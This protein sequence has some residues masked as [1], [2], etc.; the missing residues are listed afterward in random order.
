[1]SLLPPCLPRWVYTGGLCLIG[2]RA[3]LQ[4]LAGKVYSNFS[5]KITFLCFFAV[6][7]FG[8]LLCAVSVSS[9][10]LIISRAVAGVGSAGLINGTLTILSACM[11]LERRPSVFI[12]PP[13]IDLF[14]SLMAD[15]YLSSGVWYHD[16]LYAFSILPQLIQLTI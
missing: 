11:P 7:E 6:F 2:S 3:S 9:K 1:M 5:A 10:M 12:P 13:T 15:W 8:S 14:I 4:P 16:G